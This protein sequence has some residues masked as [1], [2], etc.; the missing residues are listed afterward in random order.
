MNQ[1]VQNQK[2]KLSI[3]YIVFLLSGAAALFYQVSWQRILTVYFGV[4][5]F[6]VTL[7]VSIYMLGL[8]I[9]AW[10]AGK[11]ADRYVSKLPLI[12]VAM[13]IA[14]GI[15]A[16]ISPF[17]LS[18]IGSAFAGVN[19]FWSSVVITLFLVIPTSLMGASLPI[20]VKIITNYSN[21][22]SKSLGALYF[23][24]T[25]GAAIGAL[26]SSFVLIEIFG[27]NGTIYNGAIIN[28]FIGS[29]VYL[30]FK[31]DKTQSTHIET[32]DVSS[33]ASAVSV[34]TKLLLIFMAGFSAI[35][36]EI[37]WFR[38]VGT[39]VKDSVYAFSAVLFV[40]LIG[41]SI[42][43]LLYTIF[44]KFFENRNK[45]N[46]Y[47][48]LQILI[49]GYS[50][51]IILVLYKGYFKSS[52][53]HYLLNESINSS[54]HP[55][56]GL[57]PK[58][59]Y[60][61]F[62]IFDIFLWPSIIFLVPT[63]LMG[64]TFPLSSE[65]VYIKNKEAKSVGLAYFTNILGNVLG[66]ILT[67]FVLIE[68]FKTVGSIIFISSFAFLYLILFI[69][70]NIKVKKHIVISVALFLFLGII[71]YKLPSNQQFYS[72]LHPQTDG[73]EFTFDETKDGT[74]AS[75]A[76]GEN[77]T[78]YINGTT[79][80]ARPGYYY[81]NEVI[82]TYSRAKKSSDVFVLGFGAGSIT[83]A[84][85]KFPDV[86]KVD[87]VEIS[88]ASINNLRRYDTLNKI[89]SNSKIN[90]IIEDG[91]R[92][93]KSGNKKYDVIFMDPLR[94]KTAYSN[95]I[96]SKQFFSLI[97]DHMNPGGVVMI[98]GGMTDNHYV[99]KTASDIFPHIIVYSYFMV[100]S[101]EPLIVD[102][103]KYQFARNAFS[104]NVQ[105]E[106]DKIHSEI[107]YQG[108]SLKTVIEQTKANE[109]WHPQGEYYFLKD[110]KKR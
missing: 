35:G 97:K 66:G 38:I 36:L 16:I 94:T 14:I 92:F 107:L 55:D 80:G 57:K 43:S 11:K 90:V 8:G 76:K 63:I 86:K 29:I 84:I 74:S 72:L 32:G 6:S 64:I 1:S 49:L 18:K 88:S 47:L 50:A 34:N 110:F 98:G 56:L 60:E 54:I 20:L 9:G 109:D 91:R 59:M 53:L 3:L 67:G 70:H 79:H 93:L 10:I 81:F 68:I 40:Y 12:Y 103:A 75:Y 102:S 25:I 77:L 78:H 46:T 21:S 31:N 4:G 52:N 105:S 5:Y 51:L 13:E 45:L 95:N 61:W 39:M 69:K 62:K 48:I 100:A 2:T 99:K 87:M 19:Y 96:H 89:L 24:N 104:S 83:E 23:V 17:L 7:I 82:Q 85:L 26:V 58:S 41:L 27:L 22:F 15:F 30:L 65:L 106:I 71:L 28:I 44:R 101:T 108:E 37:I 73:Q 33:N 42:G